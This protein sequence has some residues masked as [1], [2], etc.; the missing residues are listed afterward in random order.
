MI[1]S[2]AAKGM[3]FPTIIW[4]IQSTNSLPLQRPKTLTMQLISPSSTVVVDFTVYKRY[5]ACYKVELR[6]ILITR[7][8]PEPTRRGK[9]L[10][11]LLP[12][13]Q[14]Q[15]PCFLGSLPPHPQD[16]TSPTRSSRVLLRWPE[17]WNA[18]HIGTG[19]GISL[20]KRRQKGKPNYKPS[21]PER[22]E[23]KKDGDR[24]LS[25]V[26]VAGQ[27]APAAAKEILMGHKAEILPCEGG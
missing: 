16:K 5:S 1:L 6:R 3:G 20:R 2:S 19:E 27:W 17:G 26:L 10:L 7:E 14:L 12:P 24:F 22:E 8:K 25:A 4:K 18:W 11:S 23:I 9:R 13:A 21:T 15:L